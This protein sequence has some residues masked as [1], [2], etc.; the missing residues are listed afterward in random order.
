MPFLAEPPPPVPILPLL[1]HRSCLDLFFFSSSK[2]LL[3]STQLQK[4]KRALQGIF[5]SGTICEHR[6]VVGSTAQYIFR[7]SSQGYGLLPVPSG[8]K[9]MDTRV[10]WDD[11]LAGNSTSSIQHQYKE[12]NYLYQHIRVSHVH[13]RRQEFLCNF[14]EKFASWLRRGFC[15]TSYKWPNRDIKE[16]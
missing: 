4:I 13:L 9:G 8:R 5:H 15:K 2:Q 11:S 6:V 10:I 14:Y 7:P 16:L 12:V 1:W 3:D